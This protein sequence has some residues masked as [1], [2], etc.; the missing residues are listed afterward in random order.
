MEQLPSALFFET[1][2]QRYLHFPS[3]WTLWLSPWPRLLLTGGILQHIE[4]T[5]Q[6]T[7]AMLK[8]ASGCTTEEVS[9]R[10]VLEVVFGC[11][12]EEQ[13]AVRVKFA[14]KSVLRLPRS[15]YPTNFMLTLCNV[16]LQQFWRLRAGR[17]EYISDLLDTHYSLADPP[18]R[19]QRN[20][21]KSN[22]SDPQLFHFA[23][24]FLHSSLIHS[25][26]KLFVSWTVGCDFNFD[27]VSFDSIHW[28]V[29]SSI[30]RFIRQSVFLY[31][32]L[33]INHS[34]I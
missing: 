3:T 32:M 4:N 30:D 19:L 20:S 23:Y 11:A 13:I 8:E 12:P 2:Y 21:Q 25:L 10:L 16:L 34:L 31:R 14:P 17:H 24:R 27:S 9:R 1:W 5:L 18:P 29:H 6:Q 26:K 33:F 15:T 7:P 22:R 28:F